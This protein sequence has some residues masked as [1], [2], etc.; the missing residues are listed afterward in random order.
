MDLFLLRVFG[1]ITGKT[2]SHISLGL[3]RSRFVSLARRLPCVCSY[4]HFGAAISPNHLLESQHGTICHSK[5]HEPGI[6]CEGALAPLRG[7]KK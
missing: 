3:A 1:A 6:G 7:I 5:S 4:K 2:T